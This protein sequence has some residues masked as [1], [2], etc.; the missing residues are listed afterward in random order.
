MNILLLLLLLRY[1]PASLIMLKKFKIQSIFV[2]YLAFK[3]GRFFFLFR[4]I[5]SSCDMSSIKSI[6]EFIEKHGG[7][8]D[9]P[10]KLAKNSLPYR[11]KLIPEFNISFNLDIKF[12]Q[13]NVL[14]SSPLI[15]RLV[16]NVDLS[17]G[18]KIYQV[19]KYILSSL[20]PDFHNQFTKNLQLTEYTIDVSKLEFEDPYDLNNAM[21]L[22]TNLLSCK[23]ITLTIENANELLKISKSL[24]VNQL[25]SFL[26]NFI[27]N[28][29]NNIEKIN[30]FLDYINEYNTLLLLLLDLTDENFETSLS[31]FLSTDFSKFDKSLILNLVEVASNS[32][33]YSNELLVNFC[34][35]IQKELKTTDLFDEIAHDNIFFLYLLFTNSIINKENLLR[36]ISQETPEL[37]LWFSPELEKYDKNF[38]YDLLK[39]FQ[40]SFNQ[41]QKKPVKKGK[42][43][44]QPEINISSNF[45]S[46]ISNIG[47]F[48]E[49]DWKM[50]KE[51]RES[52]AN[53]SEIAVCI[54]SDDL[55]TLQDLLK[56]ENLDQKIT[57]T[58]FERC[59]FLKSNH[60]QLIEYAAFFGAVNCFKY[61]LSST[62]NLYSSLKYAVAGGCI[63]I[64]RICENS[65]CN[66]VNGIASA[67]QFSQNEIFEW[68]FDSFD[69][70]D[71][72]PSKTPEVNGYYFDLDFNLGYT[73][74]SFK[75]G[76]LFALNWFIEKGFEISDHCLILAA[77]SGNILLTK[78]YFALGFSPKDTDCL[79]FAI[80][81]GHA[82]VL[83]FI[84]EKSIEN[85]RKTPMPNF[86]FN[87][88]QLGYPKV[89]EVLIDSDL[90][91]INSAQRYIYP[92]QNLKED[93]SI[94]NNNKSQFAYNEKEEDLSYN[95]DYD[96]YDNY[97]DVIEIKKP[98]NF[99]AVKDK[100]DDDNGD[101]DTPLIAAARKGNLDVLKVLLKK[102]DI[103][104]FNS[105]NK[106]GM[107]PLM[108][109]A[110]NGFD[111]IVKELVSIKEVDLDIKKGTL[112]AGKIASNKG[113]FK[114]GSLL[115]TEQRKRARS[116][117]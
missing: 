82:N 58:I 51:M 52:G 23:S 63:E 94:N 37:F 101:K 26:T 55:D 54:R 3:I 114:I 36:S 47:K 7:G 9:R 8:I 113:Y 80:E 86:L 62:N 60:V 116:S 42:I 85:F 14:K 97:D 95:D 66:M 92:I 39:K 40:F 109:A 110:E 20:I 31:S 108:I 15:S 79:F 65:N 49:S 38:Y 25:T 18:D 53:S 35:E 76:N 56:M 17:C 32:R 50:L 11:N 13:F 106:D 103:I 16:E 98:T 72:N 57:P 64:I 105:V 2:L 84:L 73:E 96:D 78:L 12:N 69:C 27:Q 111:K 33:P 75:Y 68:I 104:N 93:N 100:N 34:K 6:R 117:S 29:S 115:M 19:N 90:F 102:K 107:T 70:L 43:K 91:D 81:N 1:N 41:Y 77:K 21:S 45:E 71:S 48:Y 28:S 30:P 61:L 67:I 59:H 88:I 10:I 22:F 44:E 87:A 5:T 74:L 83:K 112:T 4:F 46:F 89:L 99:F 24:Q